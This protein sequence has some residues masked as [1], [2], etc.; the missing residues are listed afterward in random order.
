MIYRHYKG[1][2]YF[3]NGYATPFSDTFYDKD[4][5]TIEVVAKA[6]YEPTLEEVDIILVYDS[7]V[8]STYYAYDS[9]NISGVMAFYRG[10]DGQN[11]LRPRETF[12]EE[13]T[14]KDEGYGD[15]YSVPR[16]EKVSGE[17]LFDTIAELLECHKT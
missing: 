7:N 12:H 14:V 13:V 1:G 3:V 9:K 10:L 5:T 11:W 17:Y 6:K 4:K 15:E 2:L 16:F 8:K